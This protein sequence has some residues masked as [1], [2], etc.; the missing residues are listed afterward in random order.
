MDRSL[1]LRQKT[2]PQVLGVSYAC[3][4]R[5]RSVSVGFTIESL[6]WAVDHNEAEWLQVNGLLSTWA[7]QNGPL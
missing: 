7:G 4:S 3:Y 5:V 6:Q 2:A 1:A